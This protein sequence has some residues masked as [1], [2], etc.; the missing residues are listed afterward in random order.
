MAVQ[1][2]QDITH[3]LMAWQRGDDRALEQLTPLVYGEMH[4]LANAYMRGERPDHTLQ[5]TA[6]INEAYLRL[7][8]WRNVEWKDRAHFLSVCAKLMRRILVDFA[9]SRKYAKRRGKNRQV[10]I[11]GALA[12]SK[13]RD[14]DI[15]A[16]DDALNSLAELNPR[17]SQ[18]VELR[19]FGGLSVKETAEFL[20]TSP[21]T[22]MRE[23]SLAKA[24]LY[25]ELY[26]KPKT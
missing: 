19:F 22:V 7:V 24:W 2:P 14:V 8:D 26:Q 9:R 13:E 16:L 4:R 12:I 17:K 20:K 21:R 23:W 1:D 10:A 5:A 11:E 3:L 18:I 6:L 15:S 25:G